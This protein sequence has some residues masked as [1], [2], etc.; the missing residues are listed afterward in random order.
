MAKIEKSQVEKDI[1]CLLSVK[2]SKCLD[3]VYKHYSSALYGVILNI[4]KSD[5]VAEEVLQ[6]VFL[7]FWQKAS[8]YDDK[9]SRLFTWLI[10]IARNSAIDK[11]RSSD[12][13]KSKKVDDISNYE[14]FSK[15]LHV[16]TINED[17]GLIKVING[18][19][20]K[21]KKLIYLVYYEGYSQR[22]ITKEFDIP[23]GTVK[24]RLRS[25]IV[26]LREQ[27]SDEMLRKLIYLLPFGYLMHHFLI[28]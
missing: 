19:E 9:K 28:Q 27:L 15:Q 5:E 17:H 10:N 26:A 25:A 16:N 23:L 4:V 6:D 21:Y 14:N 13:K 1:V 20:E 22:E 2:D 12:Y 8:S 18:L 7:K 24:T 11:I 3:L